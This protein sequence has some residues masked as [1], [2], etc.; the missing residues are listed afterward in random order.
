[1]CNTKKKKKRERK[2]KKN[3]KELVKWCKQKKKER[4]GKFG[5]VE[6]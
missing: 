1:M 4:N 6:R 5:V 3:R 2:R